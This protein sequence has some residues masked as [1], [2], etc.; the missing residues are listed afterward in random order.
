MKVKDIPVLK[1]R[2]LDMLPIT[3]AEVWKNLGIN[4]RDG[5]ELISIMLKEHIITKTRK[6]NTYLIERANG[7]ERKKKKNFSI[8]LSEKG[9]F[10]PCCGCELVCDPNMCKLLEEWLSE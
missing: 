1:Q 7:H 8:L 10:A 5:S 6:E 9:K 4:H 3:Q 2:V